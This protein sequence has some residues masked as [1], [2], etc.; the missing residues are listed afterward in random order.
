MVRERET[1]A[2]GA[3]TEAVLLFTGIGAV[4]LV[5][6]GVWV[7][8]HTAAHLDQ[9]PASA[10]NPFTLPGRVRIGEE[11]SRAGVERELSMPS[12]LPSRG[13]R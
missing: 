5:V 11:H 2:T 3:D 8:L 9:R 12:E 10:A 4:I 13:P 7:S 6:G 1:C